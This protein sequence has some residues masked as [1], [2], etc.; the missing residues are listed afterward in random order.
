VFVVDALGRDLVAT[1][2]APATQQPAAAPARVDLLL[3]VLLALATVIAA[4][5]LLGQALAKLHQPPVMGEVLAGILLGPSLLGRIAPGTSAVLLPESVAPFLGVLAQL[6]IVL[7]LFLVGLELDLA[8]VRR[9][10][11]ATVAVV[12]A[13]IAT[14]FVLGS[15]LSLWLYPRF[16]TNGVPFSHF[17]AFL[18][19]AMSV[20]AF[21]VLARI[22]TDRGVHASWLG[23]IALACAAVDDVVAWCLLAGVTGLVNSAGPGLA[24][25]I[26]LA[27]AYV[28][29][30]LL[31]VRPLV[32][33]FVQTRERTGRLDRTTLTA[34]LVALLLST[35]ATEAI[36]IHALFGAF[37]LGALVPAGSALAR[38]LIGRLED[39]VV[40]FFLPAFFAYTGMRTQIGL[41]HGGAEWLWCGVIVLVACAGKFGGTAVA[42]RAQGLDWHRSATLGVLMNTRGLMELIV[43]NVGL[44]LGILSPSLFAMFVVMALATTFATAPILKLLERRGNPWIRG[45]RP[46]AA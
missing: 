25:T 39:F 5:R 23:G 30:M 38:D 1:S 9:R 41:L 26:S 16:A 24:V 12:L 14:P 37:L 10:S 35:L 40:V 6:G 36:G 45:E 8:Q 4:A 34:V 7:Y 22:L 33:Q 19:I 2:V 21:P 32:V 20:T 28:V 15:V 27:G 13:S 11:R 17:T 44:D 46:P 31:L 42:A 29:V 43:L 3:H 18:G